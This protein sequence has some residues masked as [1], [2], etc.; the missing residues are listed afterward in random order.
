MV[1]VVVTESG[2]ENGQQQ[3]SLAT[4]AARNLTSTTK[5]VPQMQEIT[6]RWLLKM[7]PWV[8]VSGGAYRVNRR[9][10]YTVGD[11][12]ID[13]ATTGSDVRVIP[14]ELRELPLLRGY[15]ETDTLTT[16]ADRFTQHEY[17]PGDTITQAGQPADEIHLIAHGKVSK[18]QAGEY[19]GQTVLAILADGDF[20]GDDEILTD[21][22]WPYTTKAQ[23]ACTILTL[24]RQN[25]QELIDRSDT[26][27]THIDQR[28]N[29]DTPE[30]NKHGE[31]AILLAAGHTGEPE[32]PTTFVDYETAPREYELSVAQTVLRIHTRVADL[33]NE[34]MNQIEQQLRLTIE[35]LRERQENEII[36]NPDFGLLHN[37]DLKQRI[38]TRTGPPTPDDLDTLLSRRRNTHFFLAHPR[39]IAA[40]GR[41]CSSRGVYAPHLDVE[42][43]KV[44]AW[45]G[46]PI[47]P[48]DKI[49][50][51]RSQTSAILAMRTGE[52][53]QGVVGLHQTGI[54]DEVE[55]GLSVRYMG[56]DEKAVKSYLVSAYHSAAVL[57][58]DALGI[59]ENVEIAR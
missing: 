33:Y 34:P 17:E 27:R 14:D 15:D 55:P 52:E 20:Y 30:Q 51:S 13:F 5:S 40:F 26:L 42:G 21:N 23:T 47:F 25:L 18:T 7:L 28:Q 19:G 31:A 3:T 10:S 49:P 58:P 43:H 6:S 48:C 8:Q 54:P 57:V 22:D 4:A 41:E 45:R 59:L 56:A 37:A 44:A 39:T 53:K 12:R 16:L 1:V 24:T 35:A 36:N 38:Q 32:L 2:I 50:I 46:T 29:P 11:G 9:L